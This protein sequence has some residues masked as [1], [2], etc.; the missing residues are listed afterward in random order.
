MEYKDYYKI[1]G[2]PKNADDKAIKPGDRV[3]MLL[4]R[5]PQPLYVAFTIARG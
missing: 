4:Q 1:L 5:G 2:V 3:T